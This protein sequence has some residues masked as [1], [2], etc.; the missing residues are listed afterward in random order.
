MLFMKLSLSIRFVSINHHPIDNQ[1]HMVI[2]GFERD[3]LFT[4]DNNIK[5]LLLVIVRV[6]SITR[7]KFQYK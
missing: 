7:I 3:L 5:E 1:L 2:Q 4:F 6:I